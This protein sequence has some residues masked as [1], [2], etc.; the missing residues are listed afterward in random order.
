MTQTDTD[1]WWHSHDNLVTLTRWMA[2]QGDFSAKDIAYAVEKPW[3]Y[4]DEFLKATGF[5]GPTGG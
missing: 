1:A 5:T 3:K 2:D 4:A